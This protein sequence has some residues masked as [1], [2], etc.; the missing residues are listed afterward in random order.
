M[1]QSDRASQAHA[2]QAY[3]NGCISSGGAAP[4]PRPREALQLLALAPRDR[5]TRALSRGTDCDPE[6]SG[7]VAETFCSGAK[8]GGGED[9]A[10]IGHS[11]FLLA[12]YTDATGGQWLIYNFSGNRPPGIF[13]PTRS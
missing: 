1:A 6:K 7:T 5:A 9:D 8:S 13:L 11:R 4:R 12:G 3:E 10:G 2:R